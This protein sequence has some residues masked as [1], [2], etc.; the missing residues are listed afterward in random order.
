MGILAISP[1]VIIDRIESQRILFAEGG[2]MKF[3]RGDLVACS[4]PGPTEDG[5]AI[6]VD[7]HVEEAPELAE[8]L[9]TVIGKSEARTYTL[10]LI[11]G[12]A[13][14]RKGRCRS[15]ELTMLSTDDE[16]GD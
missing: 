9:E 12:Y 1:V 4:S 14:G 8:D 11:T 6:V 16:S 7:E 3:K 2:E 13:A 10:Y 15:T 5:L